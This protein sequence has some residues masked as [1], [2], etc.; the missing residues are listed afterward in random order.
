MATDGCTGKE[1]MVKYFLPAA[2]PPMSAKFL[3]MA[4]VISTV[5]KG[6]IESEAFAPK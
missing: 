6:N 5:R 2:A 3:E 1:T 4:A